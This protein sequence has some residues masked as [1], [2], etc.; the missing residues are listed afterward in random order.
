MNDKANHYLWRVAAGIAILG[1][2]LLGG[3]NLAYCATEFHRDFAPS[4]NFVKGPETTYRHDICLNGSW[5]FEPIELPANFREGVDP[6][7]VL[8]EPV[9]AGWASIPV[10]VPSPWNVNSFAYR[11]GEGGDFRT[12]PS[13][14]TSWEH[15]EMG[16]LKH[17]VG[18]PAEWREGRILLHFGAAAGDIEVRVNGHVAGHQFDLFF[19]FDIDVTDLI[20]PGVDNEVLIGIRKASLFDV[21]GKYGR[22]TYQGGSFWGQHIVGIWQDVDLVEVPGIRVTDVFVQPL[23]NQSLLKAEVTVRN[24]SDKADEVSL[25]GKVHRWRSLAD[26]GVLTAAE[27]LWRLDDPVSAQMAPVSV[28]VPAHQSAK[29]TLEATV[30]SSLQLWSPDA[31]NLYGLLVDVN[32]AG[33]LIDRKYQR[34]GWRQLELSGD[35]VLLNGHPITLKG[36]SWHFMGVPQMTRRYAWAWFSALHDAHMN[37]VR[38]HAEPYPEFYLDVADEM[39]VMVLDETAIWASDGGPKL[40]SDAY[41]EDTRNHVAELV[42]RDR[43]HPAVFGWSVCNEVKPVVQGVFHGPPEMLQKLVQYYSIWAKICRDLDPT[44]QWISA[45]GDGDGLGTLP[46]NMLHYGGAETYSKAAKLGKPWGVGEASGAYYATPEQV[47]GTYGDRAFQSFEARMEGVAVDAYQNLIVQKEYGAD[48]RSVFN[49]VWYGL[50]PLPLGMSDTSSAPTLQDGIFFP[51]YVE[52]KPGMQPERLGPYCTTLNPGYDP[53]LKLYEKWP[54]FDAIKDANADT[55]VPLPWK[56][57]GHEDK[58][59]DI[60]TSGP[61]SG[62]IG[63]LAGDHSDLREQLLAAGVRAED[64]SVDG[65]PA[66]LFVDGKSPPPANSRAEMNAVLAAGGKVFV[67]G[68]AP[69]TLDSLNQLLPERLEITPRKSSSLVPDA[70]SRLTAGLRLQDLYFSESSPPMI[71]DGGLGGP[72][73]EHSTILLE[74]SNTEWTK[75]NKEA[76]YAKTAM[77]VRSEL[78]RKPSGAALV[79]I[80][81]GRGELFICNLPVWSQIYKAQLMTRHILSGLGIHLNSQVDVGEPFLKTGEMTRALAVG[82]FFDRGSNAAYVSPNTADSAHDNNRVDDLRWVRLVAGANGFNLNASPLT[83]HAGDSVVYLSFWLQSPRSL[84]N[85]LLEPNIPRVDLKIR[86]RDSMELFLN[87]R[88]VFKQGTGMVEGTASN[89]ALQ[90]GWNHLLLRLVVPAAD[91][92]VSIRMT[93]SDPEFLKDLSSSLEKP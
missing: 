47:S 56:A 90:Q 55:V 35:K 71:L 80:P 25:D 53:H 82:H 77:I 91:E 4:D 78:E 83:P 44:R 84:D 2:V 60:L 38:L 14:P 30:G 65:A 81:R 20:K 87:G 8:P 75:W 12:Y 17:D 11:R 41:W 72:L 73:L 37:A 39:G 23:V 89:L 49:L 13:Y 27:T 16:W 15:I 40:D 46:I 28:S 5:S 69:A 10:K 22:R 24:D 42:R 51:K 64:M 34:F 63:V 76:E 31:P 29:I 88:G 33:H 45:D 52:G 54:L 79:S 74:A 85:L 6:A 58:L 48:Y 26:T 68:V 62:G 93:S 92:A 66:Y 57:S 70:K 9:S 36:D 21:R 7:P 43:N 3:S 19:P 32:R 59:K 1:S 67:W 86:S 61:T 50:R 18:V